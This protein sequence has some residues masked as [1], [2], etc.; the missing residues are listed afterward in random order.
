M[1]FEEL[2]LPKRRFTYSPAALMK[3]A[4]LLWTV[5]GLG[6]TLMNLV[7]DYYFYNRLFMSN[8][9]FGCVVIGTPSIMVYV[10]RRLYLFA[11]RS[12]TLV[13]GGTKSETT[14]QRLLVVMERNVW[15]NIIPILTSIIGAISISI[16]FN[17]GGFAAE[18]IFVLFTGVFFFY[19]GALG[20]YFISLYILIYKIRETG[21]HVD[22]FR[23]ILS[24]TKDL[25]RT[26][27]H[28]FGMGVLIYA[29]ILFGVWVHGKYFLLR[30][31]L[32]FVWVIPLPIIVMAYFL[33][34]QIAFH[35]ILRRYKEKRLETIDELIAKTFYDS[36]ENWVSTKNETLK[37]LL[38]WRKIVESEREWV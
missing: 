16:I 1:I 12:D 33:V 9:I 28:I 17:F 8:V 22:P 31:S 20:W 10:S 11:H 21:V 5:L 4:P 24:I 30:S 3:S 34:C 6:F 2:F 29:F 37:I 15:S 14:Y 23:S 35:K 19:L 13:N 36:S 32:S 26:Y 38:E 25:N 18:A 27:L 7:R